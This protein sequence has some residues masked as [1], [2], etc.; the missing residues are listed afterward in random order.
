MA[1]EP[2]WASKGDLAPRAYKGDLTLWDIFFPF[3]PK[4]LSSP[5][6]YAAL[7]LWPDFLPGERYVVSRGN[8]TSLVFSDQMRSHLASGNRPEIIHITVSYSY[9]SSARYSSDARRPTAAGH[10]GN[11]AATLTPPQGAPP[12]TLPFAKVYFGP[13]R[14]NG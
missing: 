3:Q 8:V 14:R 13:G 11:W 2:S 1:R 6:P 10:P 4:R 12:S 7:R 5:P 9:S